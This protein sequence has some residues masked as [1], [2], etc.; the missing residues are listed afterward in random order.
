MAGFEIE[1]KLVKLYETEVKGSSGFRA[2]EFVI[3]TQDRDYPQ[4]VKF[5]AVQEKCD[6]LSQFQEG[7][8]IKVFFDLRGRQW[9]DKYFTNLN[10]WRMERSSQ[11]TPSP[12]ESTGSPTVGSYDQPPVASG[13]PPASS[14]SDDEDLPF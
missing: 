8:N 4:F 6:I 13:F 14:P 9:Q 3:K 7:E 10:A 2:R 1:G 11:T 12:S 5:Q